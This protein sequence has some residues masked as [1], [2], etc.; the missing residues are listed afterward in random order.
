MEP[1]PEVLELLV[2]QCESLAFV[3]P[4]LSAK[5]EPVQE[6]ASHWDDVSRMVQPAYEGLEVAKEAAPVLR[7][8][9]MSIVQ[10]TN[11]S[12]GSWISRK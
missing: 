9:A 11:L 4:A 7:I 5:T 12:P 3:E 2:I 8:L 1:K 10:A 6:V